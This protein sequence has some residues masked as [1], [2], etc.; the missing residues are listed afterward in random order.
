MKFYVKELKI[1]NVGKDLR[2]DA[3]YVIDIS[4]TCEKSFNYEKVQQLKNVFINNEDGVHISE[5][6]ENKG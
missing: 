3:R 5:L 1:I 4:L 6:E 2:K